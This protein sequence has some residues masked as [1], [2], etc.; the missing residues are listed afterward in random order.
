MD[1]SV[2][3][4]WELQTVCCTRARQHANQLEIV[5][6]E[7][8]QRH[9]GQMTRRQGELSCQM[10]WELAQLN[11]LRG[12]DGPM[13]LTPCAVNRGERF[14]GFWVKGKGSLSR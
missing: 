7:Q 14:E 3:V 13:E 11:V 1:V 2:G 9:H 8:Q 4:D 5:S 10:R 12:C 6:K